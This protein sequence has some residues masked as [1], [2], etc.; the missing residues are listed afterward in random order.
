MYRDS[1]EANVTAN[2]TKTMKKSKHYYIKKL[3]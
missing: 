1:A 3:D 2:F